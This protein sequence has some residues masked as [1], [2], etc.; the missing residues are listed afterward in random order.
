MYEETVE[1][2]PGRDVWQCR[3]CNGA[4]RREV[5]E[6]FGTNV[7]PTSYWHTMPL[8]EVL[9]RLRRIPANAGTT[10]VEAGK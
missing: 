8:I 9:A 1:V 10:F 6:L 4:L 2:F 3:Y 7:L 5:E